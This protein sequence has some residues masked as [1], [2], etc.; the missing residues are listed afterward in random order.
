MSDVD[1]TARSN[2]DEDELFS[3]TEDDLVDLSAED[4]FDAIVFA[5]DWTTETLLNQ[6]QR[7]NLE[8]DPIFQR[9]DAWDRRKKSRF[10]ESLIVGLPVPQVVLAERKGR[11]GEFLVLD[12]KQRLLSVDQFARGEFKLSGLDLRADLNRKSYE[13]LPAGDRLSLDTQT[14]RTMV[15]RNW[16]REEFLYL[17]F[18]RLNTANVPLS[19]QEL[20]QALHPGPFVAFVNEYTLANPE[21][22]SMLR[23]DGRPDFRM[24]DVELLVRYFAFARYL[25]RYNGNLKDLLDRTCEGLNVEMAHGPAN[26][27]SEADACRLAIASVQKVFGEHAF[28]RW[29]RNAYERPFNRAIFDALI[30]HARDQNVRAA[31]EAAPAIAEQAFKTVCD[32]PEFQEATT[33]TTKSTEAIHARVS[34]MG[35]VLSTHL[36][37]AVPQLLRNADGRLAYA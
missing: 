37:V 12:G 29:N 15:V 26:I 25:D 28:R 36:N 3:E 24:R 8:L 6:I 14:I 20:R 32:F 9:R 1:D 13:D 4:T 21:F 35:D 17:V 18:L 33:T 10:I 27:E 30:F 22:S 34:L 31:M 2:N 16:K 19:P 5:T 23:R 7:G 11:R